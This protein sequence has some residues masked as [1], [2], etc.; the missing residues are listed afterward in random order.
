MDYKDTLNLPRTSFPMKAN[1]PQKEPEILSQWEEKKIYQ[2]LRE[3]AKDRPKYILHD[4]PPYANGHIHIGT[5]LNKILKDFI[6]KSKNM[7]GFNGE[8]VPGWDCHGLPIEHQVDKEL[9]SKKASYS[10]IEKR[11]L[12]RQFASNFVNIQREE[13]KRLGTMGEWENPYLTM[14]YDYEATIA[15][16]FGRFVGKGSVY[17]GKKPVYWC[18]SCET[19][20]A[21]AEVEYE[22]HTSPSITV[23]FAAVS[24]FSNIFPALRGKKVF[25]LIWTTTPWTVPANLAIAF[26]PDHLYVAAEVNDEVWIMAEAL[27]EQV[28]A[29]AGKTNYT[30]LKKFP[31]KAVE[32]LTCRHPLYDR[33]SKLILANY[34]TLDTGTGCV[35]TAPGHGQEDYE[36]GL[37]YQIPIYSPV[38]DQ[39]RFT[40]DV[41]FFGGQFVFE[42]NDAVI[43][44]LAETGALIH[45]ASYV[46]PYPNCW[47]C[48]NPIIFR[49]TEQWFISMEK[50][51][52]RRKALDSIDQVTW[53]PRWGRDRIYGMIRN[54]PDWC[55]SR[56]RAWGSPIIA[57]TCSACQHVLIEES[58]VEYVSALFEKKGADLWFELPAKELMPAGTRCPQCNGEEFEKETN[59]LDV[60]FDSGVS[61]AAVCEKRPNLKSPADMYLEGSDQHRGWFHSSL[62]TSVGTRG[63]APYHSVL[64]HGFVV[65]GEGKKMSKSFG[66]VIAPEEVI[67]RYGAEILRLWVAAEDYR[68]DIRIS[69]EILSRLSEAYRRIRNTCRFLLGN[70]YDFNPKKDMAP[71]DQLLELDR[72]IL[73]RLQKL[74]SRQKEAYANFEFHTVFHSLH[75][76]CAVDLSALYLDILKDRLYTSPASSRQR[77]A[78]QT[79]LFKILDALVRLMATILSYTAEE[80][81]EHI[82]GAKER[83]ESIHLTLFP[84]VEPQYIDGKLE[85]RWDLLLKV[86]GEVSR[87]LEMAR[88]DKLI[89]NSLEAAVTLNGPAKLLSFLRENENQL[90]DLFIVSQV[91]VA[92]VSPPEAQQ[93]QELEGLN[94]L[95]TR[96]PG[97]KCDRCWVYDS[98]IGE[99][100]N[101]LEVCPRCREA[102]VTI[103]S[104]GKS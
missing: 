29:K 52:L 97:K 12:C 94:I 99:S 98:R 25:V 67:K 35:H 76:F 86:R 59:I 11:K 53:I 81:W 101:S 15:R 104:E 30:V 80:V 17:R 47:R 79:A 87:V 66:N 72:W 63:Q 38:D 21:E 8:Y 88:K 57:F 3:I 26:H 10:I 4:G 68:D 73:L 64:T 39:G 33:D 74:I 7:A 14:S 50:N 83:A 20:L 60:W 102:L 2:K 70:L 82:P 42:A 48:K 71:D 91:T 84:D 9:G 75:N 90:K 100:A 78:A 18:A 27:L 62:L 16:E 65:D 56:Q 85:E 96:A 77:R 41:Q 5:A 45:S 22:D 36:S 37:E 34:I 44:K 92:D 61:Y 40:P 28:M 1:L 24:D 46:H 55:V 32:G 93:S 89:G 69:Q 58:L 103:K 51:G 31:G 23:K 43:H 19:A 49:A 13:F 6:V 54:R 95:A